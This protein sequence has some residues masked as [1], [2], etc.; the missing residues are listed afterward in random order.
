VGSF[1]FNLNVY[2]NL[3]EQIAKFRAARK[4]WAQ[5]LREEFGVAQKKNLFLRGLFGGGGSGLTKAQPE[6]NIMR[7]AFYALAAALSGAQTTALCSFD[8]AYTIPTPRAALLS[9]R[10]LEI[11][12][13]EVGLRDT[14]DPLAGSYFIETLTKQMEA[15]IIEE[16]NA[17][18]KIGGMRHAVAG[19]HIQRKVSQ[20]AYAFEKGIQNGE[21]V[22]V[23]VNKYT[24]GVE[25]QPDVELHAYDE[26]WADKQIAGLRELRRTRDNRD[27]SRTLKELERGTRAGENV[28]PYL[29]DCCRAY[30]TVG[31]MTGVWRQVFGEWEEP[32]IF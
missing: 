27:V 32:S 28:M 29:V 12:M 19:G 13:D 8:E 31:E 22:K 10:T 6:N 17:V 11:L 24:E 25:D 16:M 3:W 15:R 14:V 23:G 1:S 2:G 5:M 20:Q 21:Y 30:A 9:L 18:R 4:L 26:S 7:G